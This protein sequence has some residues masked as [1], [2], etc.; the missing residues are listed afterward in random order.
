MT[1]TNTYDDGLV[2][3]Y[4]AV[5]QFDYDEDADGRGTVWTAASRS[6]EGAA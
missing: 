4:G 2:P 1:F 6:K 5:N 3:G